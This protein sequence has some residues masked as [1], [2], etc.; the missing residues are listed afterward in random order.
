MT[1]TPNL[2]NT[3]ERGASNS[4]TDTVASYAT[5]TVE[6]PSPNTTNTAEGGT[7]NSSTSATAS[8]ANVN[9]GGAPQAAPD[10]HSAQAAPTPNLTNTAEGGTLNSSASTFALYANV[11]VGGTPQANPVF[12]AGVTPLV[13]AFASNALMSPGSAALANSM[14]STSVTT[15]SPEIREG[16]AP[17]VPPSHDALVLVA[18]SPSAAM[19][20]STQLHSHRAAA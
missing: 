11:H 6:A 15:G 7:S 16:Q 12:L 13:D 2:T 8:Y 14:S 10:E 18:A 17:R 4:S 9:V 3:A 5:V 1:P 19:T 20:R